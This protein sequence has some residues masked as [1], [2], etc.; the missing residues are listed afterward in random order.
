MPFRSCQ[1]HSRKPIWIRTINYFEH[2]I[3][4]IELLLGVNQ[5]LVNFIWVPL[6]YLCPVVHFDFL[7]IFFTVPLFLRFLWFLW[8]RGHCQIFTVWRWLLSGVVLR[9]S[10]VLW[11]GWALWRMLLVLMKMRIWPTVACEL[12][13]LLIIV[14]IFQVNFLGVLHLRANRRSL[15]LDFFWVVWHWG[16]YVA[17]ARCL[18]ILS[19]TWVVSRSLLG[20]RCV[21]WVPIHVTRG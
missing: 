2:F 13:S 1:M 3:I 9:L 6:V 16:V 20:L 12:I 18:L 10:V 8:N 5:Y 14:V 21:S 7:D 11:L 15:V 4:L 17:S 19:F